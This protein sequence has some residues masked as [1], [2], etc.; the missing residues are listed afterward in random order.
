MTT[1]PQD[2]DTLMRE[3]EERARK[4]IEKLKGKDPMKDF[5]HGRARRDIENHV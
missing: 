4:M 1:D 5:I 3:Q 2:R